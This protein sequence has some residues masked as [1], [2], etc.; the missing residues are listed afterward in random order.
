MPLLKDNETLSLL[1]EGSDGT[2]PLE[3]PTQNLRAIKA[4]TWKTPF[5][6]RKVKRVNK[7]ARAPTCRGHLGL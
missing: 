5:Q 3:I 7:S 2:L 1:K 6:D 4:Q